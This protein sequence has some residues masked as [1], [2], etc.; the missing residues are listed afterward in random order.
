M[1]LRFT[2]IAT[3]TLFVVSL[4]AAG[5]SHD[6]DPGQKYDTPGYYNGPMKTK[7]DSAGAPKGDQK[8]SPKAAGE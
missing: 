3:L 5:C 1:K 7:G 8:G 4:L 2:A 6:T